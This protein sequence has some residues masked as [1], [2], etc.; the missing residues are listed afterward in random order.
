[1]K[2]SLFY[3]DGDGS[4]R[5]RDSYRLIV[6]SA[7]FADANGLTAL[8]V[9]ERHFHAF[10]GL[11]PNPSLINAALAMVTE[12]VQLRSGSIVLPLHH[13]VRVAEEIAVVD[14][15]SGG[16][17]GVAIASG[18]TKSEFVLSSEPHSS[19]RSLLWRNYEQVT[20]LLTGETVAFEDADG[21]VVDAK[22]LPR[23]L[24]PRIPF[25]VACQSTETFIEAG[26]RG[27]NV[28]T[29]LLG[30]TVESLAPK[31]AAYRRSLERH[32]HDPET[33]TVTIMVHTFLGDDAEDVR[34]KVT[35]PFSDYLRTHYHLLEGLAR[36]MGLDMSLDNFSKD[37][38]DS[39]IQFGVEGF[40]KGR[41]LI[42]TPTRCAE[43][44]EVLAQAGIDEIACLIDFVQDYDLVMGGLP[45]LARLLQESSGIVPLHN[46]A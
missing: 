2:F 26:R 10:G 46:M 33:G 30:E 7:R 19:R 6:D 31:V 16:R 11:Y 25:W 1:M 28:L 38:L 24:Q 13:P 41:S 12:N 40:L 21:N 3:F 29:A 9:P 20:R 43:T 22:T 36:S 8:W 15:L 14:N 17:A 27:I 44:V 32:G 45:H 34:A 5:N 4:G 23:P 42:G 39:L 35:G 37:D 18:W